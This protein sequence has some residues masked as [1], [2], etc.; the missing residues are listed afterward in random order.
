MK[1]ETL[2]NLVD[3]LKDELSRY[4]EL[5]RI[6]LSKIEI[7]DRATDYYRDRALIA[8]TEFQARIA[9]RRKRR[10]LNECWT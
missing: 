4:K 7:L 6:N 3:V 2:Q 8:E 9:K 1:N 5:N 10:N